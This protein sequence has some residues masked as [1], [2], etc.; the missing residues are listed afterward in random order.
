MRVRNNDM[1]G[2]N[3]ANVYRSVA[4]SVRREFYCD[5][6]LR[7][8]HEFANGKRALRSAGITT[9]LFQGLPA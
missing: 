9:T 2:V 5:D 4:R 7:P 1:L 3:L 8:S 6:G